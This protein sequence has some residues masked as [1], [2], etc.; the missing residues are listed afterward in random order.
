M[1][2][3]CGGIVCQRETDGEDVHRLFRFYSVQR[4]YEEQTWK[5]WETYFHPYQ[6]IVPFELDFIKISGKFE[7]FAAEA[8]AGHLRDFMNPINTSKMQLR[9]DSPCFTGNIASAD[10]CTYI[11]Q[12]PLVTVRN[13]SRP[14]ARRYNGFQPLQADWN[15]SQQPPWYMEVYD[16]NREPIEK[17]SIPCFPNRSSQLMMITSQTDSTVYGQSDLSDNCGQIIG[18]WTVRPAGDYMSRE[19]V[20]GDGSGV[21]LE[22]S[23]RPAVGISCG[24]LRLEFNA[25]GSEDSIWHTMEILCAYGI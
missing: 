4:R 3:R 11:A 14:Q 9:T 20:A 13:K 12:Y 16:G 1:T 23:S 6:Y 10:H 24:I 22:I 19:S 2:T 5:F 18:I 17:L 21:N 8:L 15:G 25:R 7:K